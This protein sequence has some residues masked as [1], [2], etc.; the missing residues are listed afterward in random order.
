MSNQTKV[1]LTFDLGTP[2]GRE[3]LDTVISSH[4]LLNAVREVDNLLRSKIKYNDVSPEVSNALEE[5]RSRLREELPARI[6]EFL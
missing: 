3:A 5:I 6:K 1:I 2:A 4:E